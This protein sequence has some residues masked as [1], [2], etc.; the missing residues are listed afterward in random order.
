[1]S[2]E[3]GEYS[4]SSSESEEF[5][6]DFGQASVLP[7]GKFSK[8]FTPE[9]T[10]LTGE[11]YLC[12]VRHQSKP[13]KNLYTN[14]QSDGQSAFFNY[15]IQSSFIPLNVTQEQLQEVKNIY[16]RCPKTNLVKEAVKGSF[17][18]LCT[19]SESL[20]PLQVSDIRA[21]AKSI[22]NSEKEEDVWYVILVA[23]VFAQ[24]DLIKLH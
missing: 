22:L 2:E 7:V 6:E 21:H 14:H 13:L 8:E 15:A 20:K 5:V 16:E 4:S 12:Q 11:E 1:M 24:R 18:A 17:P 19:I 23:S 9:T 3:E 10:P